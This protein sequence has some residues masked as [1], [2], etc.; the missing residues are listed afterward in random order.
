MIED[1]L[2]GIA[3]DH[4]RGAAELADDGLRLL[5]QALGDS[6]APSGEALL[7][8]AAG[9]VRRLAELRPSMA[10]LG[11]W[12]VAY[13]AA[14]RERL[15]VA[16][17]VEPKLCDTVLAELLDRKAAQ[18]D[19]LVA[20]ACPVLAGA[21]CIVTLSHSSTV[22]AVLADAAPQHCRIVVAESRPRLEGRRLCAAL[23]AAGRR[24]RCITD[25]QIGLALDGADMALFGA[26]AVLAD[27]GVVNKTGSL[28]A[29]L[30]ARAAGKPCY[31]ACDGF[32]IDPRH[33]SHD[34]RLEAMEG[35]EVWPERA[36]I[37]DNVYF[38]IVPG[39][40][41]D[42]YLTEKGALDAAAMRDEIAARAALWRDA[43]LSP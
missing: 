6:R 21:G 24:V 38:E 39:A 23:E 25:A 30:A 29:A 43:G 17:T 33:T 10:G 35:G 27:L 20:A 3:A 14:L 28:F 8:E 40:Y 1:A 42:L 34:A 37:C 15:A 12:A 16:K 32:K 5:A 2:A 31:V 9:L 36:E 19:A 26:D 13:Y 22:E 18:R 11:N 7:A 41:V 4:D